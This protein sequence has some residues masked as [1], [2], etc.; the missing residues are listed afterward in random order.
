MSVSDL[1]DKL[2]H[3]WLAISQT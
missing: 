2:S 3:D 1:V